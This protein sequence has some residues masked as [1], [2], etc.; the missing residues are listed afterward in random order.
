MRTH[1]DIRYQIKKIEKPADK[2]FVLVQVCSLTPHLSSAHF[3]VVRL[4]QAVLA[5]IN[6]SDPEYKGGENNPVL[7]AL[8]IFRHI[9][10]IMKGQKVCK[11][12]GCLI[13]KTT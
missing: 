10:R 9:P 3:D 8:T 5:C 13:P 2:V 1:N 4:T 6:L 7:E 11:R 12:R